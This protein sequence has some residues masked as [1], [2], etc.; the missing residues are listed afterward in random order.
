M[1]GKKANG[2]PWQVIFSE[3]LK[4]ANIILGYYARLPP[5]NPEAGILSLFGQ[6]T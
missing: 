3:F 1:M 6:K 5:G 4:D 2:M